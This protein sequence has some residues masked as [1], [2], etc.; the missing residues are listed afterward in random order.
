VPLCEPTEFDRL[1]M[2]VEA[3]AAPRTDAPVWG[4]ILFGM[5]VGDITLSGRAAYT[6]VYAPQPRSLVVP[7][8]RLAGPGPHSSQSQP[9]R[10]RYSA[11]IQLGDAGVGGDGE[12]ANVSTIEVLATVTEKSHPS[13]K[14]VRGTARGRADAVSGR[15]G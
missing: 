5:I 6:L 8:Q 11:I 10:L 3:V 4:T 2:T 13:G 9:L 1:S 12:I 7:D 15:R 14:S